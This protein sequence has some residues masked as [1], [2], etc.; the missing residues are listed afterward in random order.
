MFMIVSCHFATSGSFSFDAQTLTIPRFW[1]N[2]I[3]MGGNF[4]VDVFVLIS[5][6][7]LIND[8]AGIFNIKRILKFWGQV[9]FYSIAIYCIFGIAGVSE[10]G[11][12]SLVETLFPITF[13]SWWFAS[14]YF[15]LY[16]IHPFI[17]ILL[18][19]LDKA[20]F[21]GNVVDSLVPYSDFYEFK[22]SRQ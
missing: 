15:V 16:L 20:T 9:F 5:G 6:Y 10:F 8:K 1:W 17:N 7:F 18:R 19:N 21:S 3:E 12:A 4:G 11:I 2:I 13:G 14:T 22:L